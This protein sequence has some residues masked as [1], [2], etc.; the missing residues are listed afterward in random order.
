MRKQEEAWKEKLR[1]L[2]AQE[3]HEHDMKVHDEVVSPVMADV[4]AMLKETGDTVSQ[5]GLEKL[6]KWKIDL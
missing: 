4:E 2:R 5:E 1:V 6:A 3:A